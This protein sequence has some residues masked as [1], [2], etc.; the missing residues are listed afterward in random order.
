MLV[1]RRPVTKKP[2]QFEDAFLDEL[3]PELVA[4]GFKG[5]TYMPPRNT[6]AQ[7]TRLQALCQ[8]HGLFE[9]SGVDINSSRQ[10]FNCRSA[11]PQ[12][13]HLLDATWALFAHERLGNYDSKYGLF[14]LDNPLAARSLSERGL[15]PY[16]AIGRQIDPWQPDAV[17]HVLPA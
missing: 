2:E 13:S 7:L 5:I 9:I 16:A 11:D 10:S 8:Q 15:L 12:F 14:A 17:E 1:S 6:R 4:I 3:V